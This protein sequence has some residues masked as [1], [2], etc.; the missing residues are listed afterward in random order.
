MQSQIL[1]SHPLTRSCI[2][3]A[4]PI[5]TPKQEKFTSL[6]TT[7]SAS[8]TGYTHHRPK[9]KNVTFAEMFFDIIPVM[10]STVFF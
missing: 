1:F 10:H 6:H 3:P 2:Q 8:K 4:C 5:E 9:D 7:K